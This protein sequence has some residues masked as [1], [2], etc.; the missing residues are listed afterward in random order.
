[1]L[2]GALAAS[3]RQRLREAVLLK[4]LGATRRQMRRIAAAEYLALGGLAALAGLLLALV[5]GVALTRLVFEQAFTLPWLALAGLGLGI[6][7]LT[8]LV[9]LWNSVEVF[10]HTPLELLRAD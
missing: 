10:R 5:A 7:A 2:V 9:G 1:M 4:T 6:V 3:R 8:L